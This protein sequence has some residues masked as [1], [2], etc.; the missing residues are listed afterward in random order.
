M[1]IEPL[2][3]DAS[4]FTLTPGRGSGGLLQQTA[5][6]GK[7]RSLDLLLILATNATVDENIFASVGVEFVFYWC[8]EPDIDSDTG[9]LQA[10]RS[11]EHRAPH[12]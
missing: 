12:G 7:G 10:R 3:V 11:F 4:N 9:D 6:A 8:H 2:L 5:E 1:L